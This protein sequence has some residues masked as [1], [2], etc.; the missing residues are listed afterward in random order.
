MYIYIHIYICIHIDIFIYIYICINIYADL[1]KVVGSDPLEKQ[2][3]HIKSDMHLFGHTHLPVDL[4]IEHLRYLQ[5]SL[6][7]QVRRR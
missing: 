4:E 1:P 7:M 6:G 5:W 3:R 2:I